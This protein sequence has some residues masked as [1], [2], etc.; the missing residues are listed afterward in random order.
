MKSTFTLIFVNNY[1][2][3]TRLCKSKSSSGSVDKIKM[4]SFHVQNS[5]DRMIGMKFLFNNLSNG[6]SCIIKH[7]NFNIYKNLWSTLVVDMVS[8]PNYF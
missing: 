6:D 7:N 3:V 2:A 4:H 8:P 5:V 1:K